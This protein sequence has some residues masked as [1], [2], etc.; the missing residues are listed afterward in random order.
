[1]LDILGADVA[2]TQTVPTSIQKWQDEHC[3][4]TEM[5]CL[6]DIKVMENKYSK[7]INISMSMEAWNA[8]KP[9]IWAKI[10]KTVLASMILPTTLMN[11]KNEEIKLL[12]YLF[13]NLWDIYETLTFSKKSSWL[14]VHR[15]LHQNSPSLMLNGLIWLI[16][17]R[18]ELRFILQ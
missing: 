14:L 7:A 13:D 15:G 1:M 18:I 10:L 8:K 6:E 16:I 3:L 2:W 9:V 5:A 17:K 11:L 4:P 12:D